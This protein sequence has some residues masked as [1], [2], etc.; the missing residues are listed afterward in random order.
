MLQN[1]VPWIY[2]YE[3]HLLQ[4]AVLCPPQYLLNPIHLAVR[5][6]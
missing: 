6:S 1:Q 2:L 3:P 5:F 4:A